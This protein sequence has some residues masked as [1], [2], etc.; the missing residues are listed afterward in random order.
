MLNRDAMINMTSPM[1]RGLEVFRVFRPEKL[2][3]LARRARP[4]FIFFPHIRQSGGRTRQWCTTWN[5]PGRA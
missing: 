3:R 4:A 1:G 5:Y 2:G